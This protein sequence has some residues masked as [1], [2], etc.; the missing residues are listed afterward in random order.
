[1]AQLIPPIPK[2]LLT[3]DSYIWRDWF[4]NLRNI[5]VGAVEGTVAWAAINFTGSNITDIVSRRHTDLQSLQGGTAGQYYHLTAAQYTVVV[6]KPYG[7]FAD[8]TSQTIPVNA[9]QVMRLDTT[10]LSSGITL[11]SQT[12]VVT[13]SRTL[14]TL[15]VASV[16]SGALYLGM[17]ISGTGISAGT[18]IVSQTSGTPGDVGVY[19][20]STSGTVSLGTTVSGTIQSKVMVS[21]AGVYNLQWSAEFQSTDNAINDINIWLRTGT[22]GAAVDVTR[23]NSFIAVPAR[24]SAAPG[25]E[26]HTIVA[27]NYFINFAANGYAE[28]WWSSA[29]TAVTLQAYADGTSPTK[30]STPSLILTMALVS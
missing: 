25:D 16:T 5:L 17:T 11:G 18:L 10:E 12:A 19:E 20:T 21:T 1:M 14:T 2:E 30:P 23:S 6:S 28:L 26:G 15:T 24:K 22:T 7:S 13:A 4:N 9:A 8:T 29:S 3:P 27:L